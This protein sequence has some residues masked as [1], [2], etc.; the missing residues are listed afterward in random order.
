[1]FVY[2][3]DLDSFDPIA[4][5]DVSTLSVSYAS[6]KRDKAQLVGHVFSGWYQIVD[7]QFVAF[8]CHPDTQE[9]HLQIEGNDIVLQTNITLESRYVDAW[10]DEFVV[11]QDDTVAFIHLY[12][13]P[14]IDSF[15]RLRLDM[16]YIDYED[17][18]IFVLASDIWNDPKR[19]PGIMSGL[20][21][22]ELPD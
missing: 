4:K 3:R 9:F 16:A 14:E 21:K 2:L 1:M 22:I 7:A 13:R 6:R 15:E 18:D 17:L 10:N 8:Y 11:R 12:S 20:W 5:L 19:R